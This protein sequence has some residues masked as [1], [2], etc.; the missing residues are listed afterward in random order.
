MWCPRVSGGAFYTG[1]CGGPVFRDPCSFGGV[2]PLVFPYFARTRPEHCLLPP[3]PI[4]SALLGAIWSLSIR[5]GAP[6]SLLICWGA[7]PQVSPFSSPCWDKML[8]RPLDW[9]SHQGL[10]AADASVAACSV[11]SGTLPSPATPFIL[12]LLSLTPFLSHFCKNF[13]HSVGP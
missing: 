13:S 6:H 2:C 11:A 5:W 3:S 1:F 7:P 12:L 10:Q 9:V 4:F 8:P